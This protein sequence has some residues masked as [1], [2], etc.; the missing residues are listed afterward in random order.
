MRDLLLG[1]NDRAPGFIGL[2]A[3]TLLSYF[4]LDCIFVEKFAVRSEKK[5]K[6]P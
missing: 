1:G 4:S 6:K 5:K 2:V 3:Y